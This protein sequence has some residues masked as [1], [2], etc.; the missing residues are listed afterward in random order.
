MNMK[1][2]GRRETCEMEKTE[3]FWKVRDLGVKMR[4]SKG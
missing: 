3:M 1:L 4:G 2:R